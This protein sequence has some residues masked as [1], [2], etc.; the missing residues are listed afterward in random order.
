MEGGKGNSSHQHQHGSGQKDALH[1]QFMRNQKT[2]KQAKG[3]IY[4]TQ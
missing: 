1:K 3:M 2:M 4:A